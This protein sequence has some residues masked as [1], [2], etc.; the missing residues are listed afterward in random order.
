M[1]SDT[2]R[3]QKLFIIIVI[4]SCYLYMVAFHTCDF[5]RA[6]FQRS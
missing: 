3:L 1:L 2:K 6:V 4:C 5:Q